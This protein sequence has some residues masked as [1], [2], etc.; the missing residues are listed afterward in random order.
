[1]FGWRGRLGL[2]VPSNNTTVE[3]EFGALCPEGV[4][5]FATRVMVHETEDP[6]AKTATI[7]AMH[8]RLDEAAEELASLEPAAIAYACTS[9]S[10]LD[11]KASDRAVCG[12]LAARTRVPCITASTAV[13]LAL[14]ALGARR[15]ALA[16]PYI[17][18]VSTGA[19]RYLEEAGFE[20]VAH[21]DL[22][23]LS[24]LDKGRLPPEASYRL[25]ARMNLDEADAVFVSCTNW[26]TAEALTFVERDLGLP[27]VSSN[28]ATMWALLHLAGSVTASSPCNVRLFACRP[29]AIPD[30][31]MP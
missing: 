17:R 20:V 12:R 27:A 6:S 8:E 19:R 25:V 21:D 22:E 18:E 10:F 24:N 1:V 14:Q 30:F 4:A 9:G 28:V 13:V 11:G 2:I 15:V 3:P 26:R 31:V 16:T 7:L 5:T 29:S 23:L